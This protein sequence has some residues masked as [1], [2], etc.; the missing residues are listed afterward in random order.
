[1]TLQ[2]DWADFVAYPPDTCNADNNCMQCLFCHCFTDKRSGYEGLGK[3]ASMDAHRPVMFS[4][5]QHGADWT[6]SCTHHASCPAASSASGCRLWAP[7]HTKPVRSIQAASYIGSVRVGQVHI[8]CASSSTATV[9]DRAGAIGVTLHSRRQRSAS[10][11]NI[12]ESYSES[13]LKSPAGS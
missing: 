5:H 13:L 1:M 3:W 6:N 10:A 9:Q 4:R 2:A 7:L 12:G 11:S 8:G